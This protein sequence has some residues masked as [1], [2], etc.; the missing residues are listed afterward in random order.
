MKR[1]QKKDSVFFLYDEKC[2]VQTGLYRCNSG[3]VNYAL[4][5]PP[6]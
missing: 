6:V 2:I 5:A 4:Y 3:F 1:W